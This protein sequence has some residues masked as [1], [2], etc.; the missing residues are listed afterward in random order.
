MNELGNSIGQQMLGSLG[1]LW[2][3]KDVFPCEDILFDVFLGNCK[4]TFSG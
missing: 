2:L 3:R 4:I 1:L